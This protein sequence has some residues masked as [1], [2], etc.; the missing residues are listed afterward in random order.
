MQSKTRPT[1]NE[2][3]YAQSVLEWREPRKFAL[4]ATGI[5]C[6]SE[7]FSTLKFI[8]TR[9]LSYEQIVFWSCLQALIFWWLLP[10]LIVYRVEHRDW[11][12]LGL[13]IPR[14]KRPIYTLA[15]VTGLIL[16]VYLVGWEQALLVE[17]IEQVVYI[18]FMEE[19]YYRG[20]LLRRMCDWLGDSRGLL[21]ASIL[22]GLG[23]IISRLAQRGFV[24]LGPASLVGLQTFLGGL[25][26]GFIYLRARNIWPGAIF[27]V[28]MN[29]YLS[30]VLEM[31]G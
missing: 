21:V 16:P 31:L 3:L 19:L 18:G 28:S 26:L 22:F 13:F 27:H 29:L 15:A 14:Q 4:L 10:F 25:L 20:Y 9:G 5:F 11:K 6:A 30:S 8:L 24:I 23:H 7:I 12:S 1:S 2:S 17:F